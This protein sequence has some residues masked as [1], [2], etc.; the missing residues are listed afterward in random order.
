MRPRVFVSSVM[1]GFEEM[2]AAARKGI[3]AAGGE[4]ILVEDLP[5][6]NRSPRNACLDLVESADL[7]LVV[8]GARAGWTAPSGKKVTEEE[9]EH[10][11]R[12]KKQVVAFLQ[13]GVQREPE[14]EHL[15]QRLSDYVTGHYRRTFSNPTELEAAVTHTIQEFATETPLKRN[16]PALVDDLLES[17][18]SVRDQAWIR[19]AIVPE[20]QDEVIDPLDVESPDLRDKLYELGHSTGVRLFSYEAGKT[21]KVGVDTITLHQQLR[22]SSDGEDSAIV[23]IN[24][25]GIIVLEANVTGRGGRDSDTFFSYASVEQENVEEAALKFFA[26]ARE[27]YRHFDPNGRFD[28]FYYNAVLGGVEHRTWR[29]GRQKPTGSVSIGW[30]QPEKIVAFDEPRTAARNEFDDPSEIVRRIVTMF[31]RRLEQT[32]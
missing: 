2:R 4:P 25:T 18:A 12:R 22:D 27:F 29:S 30:N 20:R 23:G 6:Q 9:Y 1:E 10:A 14:A 5:A 21:H 31:R 32:R 19:V 28:R 11:L 24:S 15:S 13:L 26:F 17:A 3:A 7:Y 16:E 8:V